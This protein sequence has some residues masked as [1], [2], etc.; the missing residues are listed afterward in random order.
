[1]SLFV[2]AYF[3]ALFYCAFILWIYRGSRRWDSRSHAECGNPGISVIVAARNEAA[4]I[5]ACLGQLRRQDYPAERTEII[6]VD[7]ASTDETPR[8]V[9]SAAEWFSNIKL[10]SIAESER[11]RAPK[12]NAITQGILQSRGEIVL[13]TDADCLVSPIWI[14]SMIACFGP[15]TGIVF[16]WVGL[17]PADGL[18]WPVQQIEYLSLIA[19]AAGFAGAGHPTMCNAN[20]LAFRR[21]AFD[22]VN[23]YQGIDHVVSGDDELLMQ[24]IVDRTHWK[25]AFCDWPK[26]LSQTKPCSGVLSFLNQRMRWGSKGLI[27]R[28]LWLRLLLGGIY[29]FYLAFWAFFAAALFRPGLWAHVGFLFAMK[30]L[31]D[32]PLVV[33]TLRRTGQGGLLK[34]LV[35]AELFQLFYVPVVSTAGTFGLYRWKSA[36]NRITP[37]PAGLP[38]SQAR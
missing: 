21:S 29:A 20:N 14:R 38:S 2:A 17:R 22:A 27:Y 34:W 23:G 18:F 26:A 4:H 37:E 1:M 33:R 31:A 8:I 10:V 5:G 19:M 11:G 24:K 28:R 32:L 15:N 3:L 6:V 9:R 30:C 35:L 25:A 36:G 16:G 7:D 13:I 12:K